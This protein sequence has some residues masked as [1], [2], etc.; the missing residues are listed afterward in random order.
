MA[1]SSAVSSFCISSCARFS[2]AAL[3]SS[4]I[5]DLRS[6][7]SSSMTKLSLHFG[8]ILLFI[9]R[10]K[11]VWRSSILMFS[12]FT[13]GQMTRLWIALA[14]LCGSVGVLLGN[15]GED[16]YRGILIVAVQ[17]SCDGQDLRP[18]RFVVERGDF[19]VVEVLGWCVGG[20]VHCVALLLGV[21]GLYPGLSFGRS[22]GRAPLSFGR[23]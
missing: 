20:S 10:R 8:F 9:Q 11:P 17:R 15:R 12:M 21:W 3:W 13:R 19:L 5:F 23:W 7:G 1:S 16:Q 14:T 4:V 6:V 2:I 18:F 22:S